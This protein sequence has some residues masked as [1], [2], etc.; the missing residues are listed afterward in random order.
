MQKEQK[1]KKDRRRKE[2]HIIC[3]DGDGFV[4]TIGYCVAFKAAFNIKK[5]SGQ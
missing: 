3:Y 2:A 5:D 1:R 4:N